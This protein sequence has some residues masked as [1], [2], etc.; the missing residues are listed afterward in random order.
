MTAFLIAA[1]IFLLLGVLV[2]VVGARRA[3]RKRDS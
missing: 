3:Q 2:A 1:P